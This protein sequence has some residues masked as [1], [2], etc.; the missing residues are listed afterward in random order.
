MI[1]KA[2]KNLGIQAINQLQEA[3]LK[4]AETEQDCRQRDRWQHMADFHLSLAGDV[5]DRL[6]ERAR[7]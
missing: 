3:S 7:D 2:L 6:L 1:Q 5:V 4:A